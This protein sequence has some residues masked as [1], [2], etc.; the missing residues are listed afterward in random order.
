MELISVLM[1]DELPAR[2]ESSLLGQVERQGQTFVWTEATL[3]PGCQPVA[4]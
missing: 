1:T 4:L 3:L 2:P